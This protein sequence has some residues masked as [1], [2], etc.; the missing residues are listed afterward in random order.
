VVWLLVGTLSRINET[1]GWTGVVSGGVEGVSALS[2]RSCLFPTSVG[3]SSLVGIKE[4][5]VAL[6]DSNQAVVVTETLLTKTQR[7]CQRCTEFQYLV[8]RC[9][10]VVAILKTF[11]NEFENCNHFAIKLRQLHDQVYIHKK[12]ESFQ[13]CYN[14]GPVLAK[15]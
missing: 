4:S 3:K 15:M 13:K 6:K 1:A 8:E 14:L 9:N 11:Q 10:F 7:L 2:C 5:A 12:V